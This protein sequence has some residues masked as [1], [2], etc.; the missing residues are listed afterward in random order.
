[1]AIAQAGAY[2]QESGVELVTY[3]RF[4]EQQWR[5][6]IE[7]NDLTGV[8]L[9]DYRDR[10]VWT[11]WAISYQT[12]RDKHEATANLLLLWSYLDHKDLWHGLLAAACKNS[13]R[14]ATLLSKW[15]GGIASSELEFSQAM[16]LLRNYS[17]VEKV[18]ETTSYAT[19]S[20]VHRW[21]HYSLG[22]CF[23]TE[24]SR[25]A[26]VTIAYSLPSTST[27]D[28]PILQRRIFP[29]V[30]VCSRGIIK[31]E[32]S[33]WLRFDKAND[34][35][36]DKVELSKTVLIAIHLL[37][38]L[39]M[40]QGRVGEAEQMFIQALQGK[41]EVLGPTHAITLD[42]VNSLGLL[43]AYSS[44]LCEAEKLYEQALRGKEKLHG[45]THLSTLATVNNL[46]NL[47]RAQDKLDKA[48]QTL[49]RA[50]HGYEEALGPNDPSTLSAVHNLGN[51][52]ADQGK[53]DKAEKMY[54]RALRGNEEAFGPTHVTTLQ[55][56]NNL[57]TLYEKQSKL[58]EA[59]QMYERV[60]LWNERAYGLDHPSVLQLFENLGCL[61]KS[62]GELD[63]AEQ[64]F[65]RA[66]QGHEE[67]TGDQNHRYL[68][69]ALKTLENMGILHLKQGEY[70]KAQ[71][72][73]TRALEGHNSVCD[74]SEESCAHLEKTLEALRDFL[75]DP[76]HPAYE[77]LW[78]IA[79]EAC[80]LQY[81][82]EQQSSTMS[83]QEVVIANESPISRSN[84]RRKRSKLS[85]RELI[86][87]VF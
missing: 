80:K 25:L 22:M 6:L 56:V 17:L 10:S 86:R 29:H 36:M 58:K 21:A 54:E 64:M 8:I 87:S 19:H 2:L 40:D 34:G 37:A 74:R 85:I 51:L 15:I 71:A 5:K 83:I 41:T 16:Q 62:Q 9:Q 33:W 24:L 48:E 12:I 44:K 28:Y 11:T 26:V 18:A 76:E 47:Y 55:T 27:P 82:R 73:Y 53:L 67:L 81:Y 39:Y 45:L 14:A 75:S 46:G 57:G 78:A 60:F 23:V 30:Q 69:P 43:Y 61:Y 38:D 50:L 32:G 66:L 13:A 79:S 59:E 31:R 52:Y 84:E 65:K 7:S 3:L 72:V 1:L 20:V 4:Y 68:T 35:D 49:Q 63:K 70:Y 42:T 77:S